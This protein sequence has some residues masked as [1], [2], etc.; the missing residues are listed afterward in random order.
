MDNLIYENLRV[1]PPVR[2]LIR[3]ALLDFEIDDYLIKKGDR[4]IIPIGTSMAEDKN[5]TGSEFD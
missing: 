4:L 2:G 5:W 1:R 3:R